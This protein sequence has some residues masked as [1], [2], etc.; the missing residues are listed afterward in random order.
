MADITV[1]DSGPKREPLTPGV[2]I[3]ICIAV[4]ELGTSDDTYKGETRKRRK[5]NICWELPGD[6]I[7]IDGQKKPTAR[8][9]TYSM[10]LGEKSSLRKDLVAWRGREFTAK[11]LEGFQLSNLLGKAAQI[12][13]A[14]KDDGGDRI[15]GIM[16]VM[17]G[18]EVPKPFNEPYIWS[19]GSPAEN[20]DRVPNWCKKVITE[21][22]EWPNI[23][24]FLPDPQPAQQA[25]TAQQEE[26]S[27]PF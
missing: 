21:C 22:D 8:S 13:I 6:T 16:P 14:T 5:V 17:Q 18:Q 11:E 12:N 2:R 9:K 26:E 7:E 27:M 19:I 20:W 25:A 1:S 15:A 24:N 10:S 3:G 4:I 23:V